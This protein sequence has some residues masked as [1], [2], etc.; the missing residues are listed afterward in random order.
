[1]AKK[2]FPLSKVYQLI[3]PG[4]VIMVTTSYKDKDN[5][6]TMS[7]HTMLDFEPPLIGIVM[8][9]QSY[10]FNTLKKTKECVINIPTV[11]LAQAVVGVG[12]TTG[13]KIDKFKKFH[14]SKEPASHVKAPLIKECYTNL[15]CKVID[16]KLASKYNFFILEVLKAWVKPA[17]KRPKTIHH[18]GGR[19]FIV[20]GK[21]IKVS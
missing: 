14:L 1:M 18:C 20:D 15:E 12:K 13:A 7:W 9:E 5:V 6:M 3:E 21:E 17:K 2:S 4:P 10:S 11:E 16:T 8:G 19:N